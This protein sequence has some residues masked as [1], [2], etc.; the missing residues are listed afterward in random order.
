MNSNQSEISNNFIPIFCRKIVIL[1]I[2]WHTTLNLISFEIRYFV[3]CVTNSKEKAK[4][5]F[6]EAQLLARVSLK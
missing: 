1:N 2:V 4:N 3:F 5:A 6:I